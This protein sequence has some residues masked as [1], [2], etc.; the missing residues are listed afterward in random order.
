MEVM[1]KVVILVV[2]ML[3]FWIQRLFEEKAMRNQK[4]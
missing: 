1:L 2:C 4:V 3:A